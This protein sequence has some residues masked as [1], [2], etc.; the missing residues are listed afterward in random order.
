MAI[1]AVSAGAGCS[2][3]GAPGGKH[4]RTAIIAVD[5][6]D[7]L[8]DE[9]VHMR[10]RGLTSNEQVT[11]TTRVTDAHGMAWSGRAVFTADAKGLIDLDHAR[12]RTG[13]YRGADGMGLFWSMTPGTGDP[14]TTSIA[15]TNPQHNPF[16]E[17]RVAVAS[18]GRTIAQRMLTRTFQART[19]RHEELTNTKD[20][21][22][23]ELFLPPTGAPRRAPVLLLGGSEGGVTPVSRFRAALLASRGHPALALCYFGCPGRPEY[24][25][26]VSLEYIASA[27][28]FLRAQPQADP[29]R[30]MVA[31][32][33][34][35]SEAAQLMAQYYPDLVRDAVVYAP[36]RNT[37]GAYPV[38]CCGTQAAWTKGGKSLNL[39][40]IPLDHVR[41]TVLAVAGGADSVWGSL[42]SARSIAQ[43]PN[44]SGRKA[45]AL[46]YPKAGHG[47]GGFPYLPLG[48]DGGGT[49]A[50]NE[51][52]RE[53]SWPQ[54]LQLLER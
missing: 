17:I 34:R 42:S 13:T 37:N 14:D 6:S 30:L 26:D 48:V 41:G 18:G 15:L 46:L 2:E 50:A 8:A 21:L 38:N 31:G 27:A 24:L 47:I 3:G 22:S 16:Y 45:K 44:A 20:G 11:V 25:A 5:K 39:V 7:A 52:S 40:P 29:R 33:S 54:L 12:P 19:V 51:Q 1:V 36:S 10:I 53:S 28:R 32:A 23:G 9:P 35:G 43:Q 49:R 4:S